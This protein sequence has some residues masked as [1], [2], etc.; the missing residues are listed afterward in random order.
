R[1]RHD[2]LPPSRRPPGRRNGSYN[3]LLVGLWPSYAVR[4]GQ[5]RRISTYISQPRHRPNAALRKAAASASAAAA[6]PT[7]VTPAAYPITPMT[8]NTSP[9]NWANRGGA[10]SSSSRG[11]PSLRPATHPQSTPH[12]P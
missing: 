3:Y 4:A 1:G 7:G 11:G 10:A 5:T 8:L 2:G 9:T 12:G 6:M